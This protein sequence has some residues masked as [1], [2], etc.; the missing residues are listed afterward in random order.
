MNDT[1]VRV[2]IQPAPCFMDFINNLVIHDERDGFCTSICGF[3]VF[4]QADEQRRAFS[5]TT[6]ATR[7]WHLGPFI[8]SDKLIIFQQL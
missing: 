2:P 1:E 3:K 6:N 8:I 7:N 4:Q 5:I